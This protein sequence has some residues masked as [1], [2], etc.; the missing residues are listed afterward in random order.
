MIY[1]KIEG[2]EHLGANVYKVKASEEDRFY[3]DLEKKD[4]EISSFKNS[5]QSHS[6]RGSINSM[7]YLVAITKK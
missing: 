5:A 1:P 2:S 4:Y 3:Q 6:H 7:I